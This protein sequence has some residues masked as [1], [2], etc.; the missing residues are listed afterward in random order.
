MHHPK[1]LFLDEPTTGLD[2]QTRNHVWSYIENLNKTE[3]ITVFFTTHYIEEAEKA[4]SHVAIM[5]HG[6]IVAQG[7]PDELK[8]RTGEATLENAFIK[9]TGIDLRKDSAGGNDHMRAHAKAWGRR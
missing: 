6:K 2:P 3:G 8:Q 9:L 1:I 7:S 4:A 5:D